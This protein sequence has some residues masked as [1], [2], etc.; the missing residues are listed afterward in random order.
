MRAGLAFLP[1]ALLMFTTV[2]FVPRLLRRFGTKP[3]LLTGM[4]LIT[5]AVGWSPATATSPACSAR[6]FGADSLIA[7]SALVLSAFVI[8]G[9][10]R[11]RDA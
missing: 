10:A 8:T 1:M 7:L 6:A 5:A 2:R 3:V 4:S 11:D 9:T